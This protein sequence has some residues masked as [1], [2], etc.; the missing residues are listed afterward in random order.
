MEVMSKM[1]NML[2]FRE[3]RVIN[4]PPEALWDLLADTDQLNEYAGIFP[5]NFD[6]FTEE[7][8]EIIRRADA[9]AIGILSV[10]WKEHVFE[11]V[12]Y[13]YYTIEREYIEG[14]LVSALWTVRLEPLSDGKTRLLLNGDF[15]CRHIVGKIAL[16]TVIYPQLRNML[17]YATEYE[18]NEG[19]KRPSRVKMVVIEEAR[20]EQ[21][22]T[23]LE[24]SFSNKKMVRALANTVR[25]GSDEEVLEMQP[26]RWAAAYHFDRF[27]S[28]ELFLLAN[29]VGLL[30]YDWNLMCPNCRVPKGKASIL[31][32]MTST[33]HCELCGVDYDLDFDRY[34]EMRFHVNA[35][36]RQT[37]KEVFCINGPVKS[38]HILG[39][40]RVAPNSTKRI[41]WLL[42]EEL[43]RCRT[44]Q[45]NHLLE[46]TDIICD[47]AE[48]RYTDDGFVQSAVAQAK[49]YELINETD[50]EIVIVMEKKEWDSYALTARE[51]TSLQLFRDLLGTEVLAPG[52]QIGVG[53]MA[54]MFTDLKD[55]TKLYEQIGDAKAY[56]DVQ[57]HFDY[58]MMHIKKHKG[59][60]VKTIGDSVMGAFTSENEAFKASVAIQ[61]NLHTL[62]ENL[63][64]PVQV[65]VGFY[66]GSVIA[67]NANELLDYFGRTVNKAARIQQQSIGN[68]IVIDQATY[69]RL[70]KELP[71][72]ATMQNK[73]FTA[74]LNGFENDSKL[75]QFTNI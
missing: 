5:V 26:Y 14:P 59:T 50:K 30:D 73:V 20:L 75:V 23:L 12:R 71:E 21:V 25:Y 19:K 65:K 45:S 2:N 44:L 66:V 47:E 39:Q 46:I 32:Q 56:S 33:V 35:A 61:R 34:V 72:I 60:V 67:V 29:A 38:P 13:A 54:I 51:V 64:Q 70:V 11:W 55:S 42:V 68:D 9:T 28:V 24:D 22:L 10:K 16:V 49:H 62:N 8:N 27:E 48:I 74:S 40:F 3:E 6:Q 63:S 53:N 41:N 52:L 18:K 1:K 31:K 43:F 58:I 15:I 4:L 7:N 69:E 36:I 17:T 57:K 37:T